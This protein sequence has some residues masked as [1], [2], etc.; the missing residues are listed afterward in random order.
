VNLEDTYLSTNDIRLHVIQAGPADS[1][2]V[3]LLHGFPEFWYGWRRQINPLA[4]AGFRVVVPDQRGYNL[5]D[6]PKGV[7]AYRLEELSRDIVGLLDSLGRQPC[8]LVG[9]DWGAAVA[10][11]VAMAYPHRVE[12][13]VIMSVPHPAVM[14]RF[15]R[16]SLRQMLKSWYIGFFQL[17]GLADWLLGA[18][19]CAGAA[20]L[21]AGSGKPGTFTPEDLE[22]YKRAWSQ[23]AALTSM[24]HWYRALL[25]YPPLMPADKRLHMPVLVLWGK[26]DV[27]LSHEMAQPSIDLCD[28]GR[29]IF[30]DEASHWVQHDEAEKVN[31]HLLEFLQEDR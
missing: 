9:H 12:R 2:L 20:R 23:P 31:Q 28:R 14:M 4:Q 8:C 22:E 11:N 1:S 29:L 27:A 10:W 5:S 16:K 3:V 17:P 15:L 24:L 21:L 6:K 19:D 26:Q 30:F 18:Q 25:R 13:L 7:K